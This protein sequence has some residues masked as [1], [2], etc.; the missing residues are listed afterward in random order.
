MG[1]HLDDQNPNVA[2]NLMRCAPLLG[3][4]TWRDA[5]QRYDP[6]DPKSPSGESKQQ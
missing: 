3:R 2:S 5:Q 6:L 4:E 1:F